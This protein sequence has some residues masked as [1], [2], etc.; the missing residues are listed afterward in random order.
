MLASLEM[1]AQRQLAV[2]Y[3]RQADF[4]AA[5]ADRDLTEDLVN[6][7]GR[8]GCTEATILFTEEPS[9]VRV[10]F[11]SKRWLDVAALAG[12]FGGGGHPRAAGARVTGTWDEVVP[13]VMSAALDAFA[14][15]RT[16]PT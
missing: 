2:M 1:H 6:E 13:R 16:E 8:L 10:N 12:R 11:R 15:R 14:A 7:A 5:G 9:Q 3:L 4:A